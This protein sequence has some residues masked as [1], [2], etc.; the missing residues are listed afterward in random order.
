M[1]NWF[2]RG[3][4]RG[5]IM[6][7]M[8]NTIKI[9]TY[10]CDL[11]YNVE[12]YNLQMLQYELEWH[13]RVSTHAKCNSPLPAWSPPGFSCRAGIWPAPRVPP[14]W[15]AGAALSAPPPDRPH[16]PRLPTPTPK[17]QHIILYYASDTYA[18]L[19]RYNAVTNISTYF[20]HFT[21]V[22]TY[23]WY[24]TYYHMDF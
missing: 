18:S 2:L 20:Q 6:W 13:K 21:V 14:W 16:R 22:C 24:I 5:Q 8:V 23:Q 9:L 15:G 10:W 19:P 12:N 1:K 11:S 4:S 17:G 3:R 7:I